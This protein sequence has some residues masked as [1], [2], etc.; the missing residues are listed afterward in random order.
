MFA[1]WETGYGP[2]QETSAARRAPARSLLLLLLLII[3]IIIIILIITII[4]ISSNNVILIRVHARAETL[5]Q[6]VASPH[7]CSVPTPLRSTSPFSDFWRA[8]PRRLQ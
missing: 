1:G 6:V 5:Q 8:R 7:F 2:G 4:I 3:I